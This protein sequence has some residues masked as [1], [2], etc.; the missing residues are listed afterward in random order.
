VTVRTLA[1]AYTPA[2]P[3][4]ESEAR[5]W[6]TIP[7]VLHASE[8]ELRTWQRNAR[9]KLEPLLQQYR[10]TGIRCLDLHTFFDISG[11]DGAPQWYRSMPDWEECDL[12]GRPLSSVNKEWT[13]SCLT[14]PALYDMVDRTFR[15]LGFLRD[16]PA[17]LGFHLENEPHLGRSGDLRNFG[18]NPHTRRAFR[19][20]LATL[21]REITELNRVAGTRYGSF[22][23]V[24]ISDRNWLIQA[25]AGRFRSRLIT[26]VYEPRLA[27]LAKK[28]FPSAVTMTRL[29]TGNWLSEREGE[30]EI[31]GIDFTYLKD[32]AIDV[33]SW[34]HNWSGRDPDGFGQLN[35]T[36]G[37]LRGSG[38]MIGMTEP[39]VQRYGGGPWC[40]FRPEELLN[41][42]Y[43]GLYYNF[44]MFNLH[45]WDRTG[46]W[47]IY[48]E[49]FGAV[50]SKHPETLAMVARLRSE[51]ERIAPFET[52]G[53]PLM[54]PLALVVSRSAAHFPGAGGH[55]YG[56]WLTRLGKVMEQP[57]F[58][59]YDVT[60]VH[61]ADLEQTLAQCRGAM[62]M[63]ACLD[64]RSRKVLAQFASRGGRVMVVGARATVGPTYAAADYPD[65]YPVE[66]PRASLADATGRNAKC[67]CGDHPVTAGLESLSLM[68]AEPVRPRRGARAIASTPDG[69][70]AAVAGEHTEGCGADRRSDC[71]NDS[72]QEKYALAALRECIAN[73]GVTDDLDAGKADSER[74]TS[75]EESGESGR[76]RHGQ[77]CGRERGQD[78]DTGACKA[79]AA[80]QC[81]PEKAERDRSQEE[82]ELKAP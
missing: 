27:A 6:L 34:S 15:L 74:D 9:A 55:Y 16:E 19:Q 41:I 48:N 30:R 24:E 60:E 37:L 69:G 71:V 31:N 25:M 63:D 66:P 5:G 35:V 72:P 3:A 20:F 14:H 61:T 65:A 36:G 1:F 10:E 78:G 32:S 70:A 47:A 67:G 54:P 17:F 44:R 12:S 28:H 76:Q 13:M 75:K 82:Y 73:N 26:G 8:A 43:R 59:C 4:D 33:V 42:I 39:H 52:F 79:E 53:A 18:G 40:V 7:D 23:G 58:T 49:P 22:E 56:N 57:R 64:D 51:L 68:G 81:A 38:K 77:E 29:E 21:Y 80:D 2:P 11:H 45:S 46:A 62:V 50:Y